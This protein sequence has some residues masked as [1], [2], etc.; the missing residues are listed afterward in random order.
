MLFCFGFCHLSCWVHWYCQG[1]SPD[2]VLSVLPKYL[3]SE[4]SFLCPLLSRLFHWRSFFI[5]FSAASGAY[6]ASTN[7]SFRTGLCEELSRQPDLMRDILD[8]GFNLENC[9][10]WFE[11]VFLVIMALTVVVII[12]RVSQIVCDG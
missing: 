4:R 8:M 7:P 6:A 2:S 10:A 11:R 3:P 12:I 5:T 9:E 1:P